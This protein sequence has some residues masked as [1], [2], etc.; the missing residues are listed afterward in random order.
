MGKDYVSQDQPQFRTLGEKKEAVLDSE[1]KCLSK[2]GTEVKTGR[3]N[4]WP[5]YIEGQTISKLDQ[6]VWLTLEGVECKNAADAVLKGTDKC[7]VQSDVKCNT[8][9]ITRLA[10]KT[11]Q[12]CIPL[13]K[14]EQKI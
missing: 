9:K 11:G 5:Y 2:S 14:W 6:Y 7:K 12:K 4:C 1:I 3:A 10:L 13:F 8:N